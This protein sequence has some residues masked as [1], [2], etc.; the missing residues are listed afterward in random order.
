MLRISLSRS[1]LCMTS[2]ARLPE[3]RRPPPD[4]RPARRRPCPRPLRAR[5]AEA[6]LP[7]GT[8]HHPRREAQRDVPGGGADALANL[9]ALD[10]RTVSVAAVGDDE[11]GGRAA[12]RAR[13]TR[14]RHLGGRPGRGYHTPIEVACWRR[15]GCPQAPGGALRHRGPAPTGGPGAPSWSTDRP[16][17]PAGQAVALSRTYGYGT[18]ADEVCSVRV[19]ARPRP[20]WM[21]VDSRSRVCEHAGVDGATPNLQELETCAGR[22]L[23]GDEAVAGAAEALRRGLAARVVLATRGPR[24]DAR[25]AGKPALHIPVFGTDEVADV[26]GA[27]DTVLAVLTA[28]LAV[29]GVAV[30]GGPTG[31][32]RRGHRGH[33][34]GHRH[35]DPGQPAR[36]RPGRARGR[37]AVNRPQ[38]KLRSSWTSLAEERAAWKRLGILSVVLANGGFDLLH[39]GH[40][41]Y[42]C[43]ARALGRPPGGGGQLRRL[44]T[45]AKGDRRPVVPETGAG[46]APRSHLWMVDRIVPVRRADGRGGAPDPAAPR[47]TPRAPTTRW[48]RFPSAQVVAS[49]GGTHGDLRRPQG[50]RH[51]RSHLA[52]PRPLRQ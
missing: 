35:G 38:E 23:E 27:G 28:A 42:L 43:A 39:V 45:S 1:T 33:E 36:R 34:A 30:R 19:A 2:P 40:V 18:V 3:P 52:H 20:G 48:R 22:A 5:H 10:V 12:P 4:R 25:R 9:A 17:A 16:P 6:H 51:H 41:R 26:T 15:P 7:R 46:R 13:R 37:R 8:S 44:G 21:C 14:R 49:Y 29:G 47:C 24:H 11:P 32:L 31:Q 50:P